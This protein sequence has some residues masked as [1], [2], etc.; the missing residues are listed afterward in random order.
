MS[1][2]PHW[3]A[4]RPDWA[5][6]RPVAG[7]STQERAAEQDRA[8][9]GRD[10]RAVPLRGGGFALASVE[11]KLWSKSRRLYTYLRHQE[12]GRTVSRYI[13]QVRATDRE[14][15]L[16]DAWKEARAKGLLAS[17]EAGRRPRQQ[18]A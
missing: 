16:R 4:T 1:P 12:G 6:F 14:N 15:A 13:G 10:A 17:S 3:A 18:R 7:M 11:L 2:H 5:D 8:A 9:G